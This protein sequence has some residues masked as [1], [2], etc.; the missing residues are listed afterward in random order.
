MKVKLIIFGGSGMLGSM[1]YK[2][3]S[4]IK[5]HLNVTVRN[6]N[7]LSSSNSII[8]NCLKTKL[9][10]LP[11]DYDFAINCIG[12]IR[13]RNNLHFEEMIQLNS[14]WPWQ[15]ALWCQKNNIKLIHI[16]TDCVFSGSKGKYLETDVHDDLN[17]YGKSKSL[18]E[19]SDLAM[20]LR[21]SIIGEELRGFSS[22][23]SWAKS[24]KG[25]RV[26]GFKTHIW[27]GL[28]TY[29]YAQVCQDIIENGLFSTGIYHI[30]AQD[31]VSKFDLLTLFNKKYNL[32]LTINETYP[33]KLDRS[34]RSL[35]PLCGLLNIPTV[36]E[37]VDKIN[38]I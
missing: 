5:Y 34:L 2:Y 14:L 24:Q 12:D 35:K 11:I 27:N 18:G 3:F 30:F 29:K 7:L 19:C 22:L 1:V 16:T 26:D 28:T 38:F 13:H 33:Q 32:N 4:N 10:L 17:L 31:D 37:M 20:V 23:V 15:L 6:N 8:F 25:Q 36:S 9:N 21:T